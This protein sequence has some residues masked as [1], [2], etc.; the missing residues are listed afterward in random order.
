MQASEN[1]R[2]DSAALL[3]LSEVGLGSI[4]HA[5]HLPLT[6]YILSLN[7]IF[8]LS[9]LY[10][11]G[12]KSWDGLSMSLWA[13]SLKSLAPMGKKITPMLAITMQGFLFNVPVIFCG[14]NTISLCLGA[15]IASLWGFIQPFLLYLF[16]FGLDVFDA[17]RKAF[18]PYLDIIVVG[19][20]ILKMVIACCIVLFGKNQHEEKIKEIAKAAHIP[21]K[22]A[23]NPFWGA[24]KDI[25]SFPFLLT[26]LIT[27]LFFSQK[28]E[29]IY[30]ILR[31]MGLGFI[32]FYFMRVFPLDRL[33][34]AFP[35][36]RG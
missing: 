21:K 15:A 23:V 6:G 17:Y 3:A 35:F 29:I 20:I 31:P 28:D 4:M 36:P 11:K 8:L 1:Q 22:S 10:K 30:M 19:C 26:V 27:A 2:F 16:I 5:W 33:Q 18:H 12:G 13:A 14:A 25:F 7:Q 9:R 34:K 32:A 24:L